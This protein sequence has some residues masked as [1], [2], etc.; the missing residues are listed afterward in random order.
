MDN[1]IWFHMVIQRV[2]PAPTME[3]AA[4]LQQRLVIELLHRGEPRAS[5]WFDETWTEEHGNYTNAAAGYVGNPNS[6]GIENGWKYLRRD[7]VGSGGT[8]M[9][10]GADVF[11]PRLTQYVSVVSKQQAARVAHPVTGKRFFPQVPTITPALWK[12][13]Q[14]FDVVRMLL[15]HLDDTPAKQKPW[16]RVVAFFAERFFAAPDGS[17]KLTM[18]E[19]IRALHAEHGSI[20]LARTSVTGFH[21]PSIRMMQHV[22]RKSKVQGRSDEELDILE[23]LTNPVVAAYSELFNTPDEFLRIHRTRNL[24]F[25]LDVMESCVRYAAFSLYECLGSEFRL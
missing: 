6:G 14:N 8:N 10:I 24:E 2:F 19:L 18:T 20:G 11:V 12:E 15:S 9:K 13:V 21:F 25:A 17:P 7:T 4:M 16:N 23:K 1:Y 22:R 5:K 3:I